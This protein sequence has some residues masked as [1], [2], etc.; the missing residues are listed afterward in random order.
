MSIECPPA[1]APGAAR[2]PAIRVC[3]SGEAGLIDEL[4]EPLRPLEDV[5]VGFPLFF[6]VPVKDDNVVLLH[7]AVEPQLT[8]F[9]SIDWRPR[10]SLM[11]E[12]IAEQ[13]EL[14]LAHAG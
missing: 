1:A 6:L 2:S 12:G 9:D 3:S 10:S 8:V 7:A 5:R 4:S 13:H 14:C 11:F